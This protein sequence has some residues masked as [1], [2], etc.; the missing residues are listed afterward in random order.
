MPSR[1]QFA[2]SVLK[3]AYYPS[4]DGLRTVAVCIVLA[5]HGGV[6]Y[7]RSGGTGVDLFFVLSGFLITTILSGE[8]AERGSISF[9]NF[10]MRRFL[11][12][13]PA[14]V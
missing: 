8:W 11:R 6:P 13:A 9:R 14:L 1:S 3:H 7:F 4:L 10:Y 2:D 12:L 5:A